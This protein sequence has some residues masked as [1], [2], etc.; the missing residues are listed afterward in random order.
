MLK[1]CNTSQ[2]Y[3]DGIMLGNAAEYGL[4]HNRTKNCKCDSGS[5]AAAVGKQSGFPDDEQWSAA[6]LVQR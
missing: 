1:R 3:F 6:L 5:A 4:E 2:I